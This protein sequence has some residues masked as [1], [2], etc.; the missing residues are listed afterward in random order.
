MPTDYP[1]VQIIFGSGGGITGAVNEIFIF[2][3][4][5]VFSKMDSTPIMSL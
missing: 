4:G 5:K 2:D 1:K 3:N